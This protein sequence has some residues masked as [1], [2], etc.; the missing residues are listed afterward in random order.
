MKQEVGNVGY[1]FSKYQLVSLENKG[2]VVCVQFTA[3]NGGFVK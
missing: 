3:E 1:P 2:K